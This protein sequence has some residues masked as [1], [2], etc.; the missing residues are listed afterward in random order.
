MPRDKAKPPLTDVR[1][2]DVEII[3]RT[4]FEVLGQVVRPQ[5][6][7]QGGPCRAC[8]GA[9]RIFDELVLEMTDCPI[10]CA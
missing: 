3:S 4:E 5:D 9:K 2:R 7:E 1:A 6:L 10:C 8:G